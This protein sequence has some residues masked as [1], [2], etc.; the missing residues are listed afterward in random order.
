M[1][2]YTKRDAAAKMRYLIVTRAAKQVGIV[3]ETHEELALVEIL[4][5]SLGGHILSVDPTSGRILF[6][7]PDVYDPRVY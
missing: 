3:V 1:I 4:L 2:T 5:K 6:V 7:V